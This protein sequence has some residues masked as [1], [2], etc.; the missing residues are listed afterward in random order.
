MIAAA[1]AGPTPGRESSASA[2]A[3][4]RFTGPGRRARGARRRRAHGDRRLLLADREDVDAL[5]VGHR[6]GEVDAGGV[7]R[8]REPAGGRDGVGHPAARRQLVQARRTPPRRPRGPPGPRAT[9][10][11]VVGG[12][13]TVVLANGRAASGG[14]AGGRS[15]QNPPA[16]ATTRQRRAPARMRAGL[17]PVA[18][19]RCSRR[20]RHVRGG[21]GRSSRRSSSTGGVR[22][23]VSG[24][25]PPGAR[26]GSQPGEGRTDRSDATVPAGTGSIYS[27]GAGLPLGF[28]LERDRGG[29]PPSA[30]S[31]APASRGTPRGSAR[32]SRRRRGGATAAR[33]RARGGAA[34][35]SPRPAPGR[36]RTGRAWWRR[37]PGAAHREITSTAPSRRSIRTAQKS[38]AVSCLR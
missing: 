20:S 16:T 7:G 33:A 32:R 1:V 28:D 30:G 36:T 12:E 13:A 25:V 24:T 9:V 27:R 37:R 35:A 23:G 22:S 11:A 34:V 18:S 31:A 2:S 21:S 5:A 29:R 26:R 14:P 19:A 4:L 15:S 8:R 3:V 38:C 10:V 6:R 17:E